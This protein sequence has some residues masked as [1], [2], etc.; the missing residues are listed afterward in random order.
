MHLLFSKLP[1]Y[2][3]TPCIFVGLFADHALKIGPKTVR[4]YC[5]V[6]VVTMAQ[7]RCSFSEMLGL[8]NSE[9]SYS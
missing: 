8:E 1:N 7:F 4:F 5:A 9:K 6:L 2:F 3:K